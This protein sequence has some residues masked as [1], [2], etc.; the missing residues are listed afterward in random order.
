MLRAII[1]IGAALA[2][3]FYAFYSPFYGL[4]VYLWVA[5]FRAS[6]LAWGYTDSLRLSFCLAA[7]IIVGVLIRREKFFYPHMISYLLLLL[8]LVFAGSA[9]L[10]SDLKVSM[11]WL[12]YLSKAFITGFLI[13]GLVNSPR[14]FQL[15]CSVMA[16]SLGFFAVKAGIFSLMHGGA[17]ILSGPGDLLSDNNVFALA[18]VMIIPFLYYLGYTYKGWI[19][20]CFHFSIPLAM[21][22]VVATRSR[23]GFLALTFLLIIMCFYVRG[24]LRAFA[25]ILGVLFVISWP[26]LPQSY[27]ERIGTIKQSSEKSDARASGGT[28]DDSIKGRLHFWKVAVA[29]ANDYPL[30]GVGLKAY[31]S[32]YDEYDTSYGYYGSRRAVHSAWFQLLSE[33]GWIAFTIFLFLILNVILTNRAIRKRARQVKELSWV[34]P[35]TYMLEI[36]LS[37]FLV[38]ATFLSAAYMDF[39]Y[40]IFFLTVALYHAMRRQITQLRISPT[41]AGQ[42]VRG[43]PS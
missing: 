16:A 28:E 25:I 12:D 20:R 17:S 6:D 39:L 11:S 4:L 13:S 5:Y 2:G 41:I 1:V 9:L 19:K 35:Y 30:L 31:Q 40:H 22:C 3:I 42:D 23:G 10:S 43:I 38:G 27:H 29:M 34:I 8:W 21:Y 24:R 37:S 7:A 32:K 15:A 14:K 26:M 18:V 36:S 33:N